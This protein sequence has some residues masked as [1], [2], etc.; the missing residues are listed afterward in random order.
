MKRVL[1]TAMTAVLLLAPAAN[2]QKVNDNALRLK[3]E[4]SDT[5]ITDAK[6]NTKAATWINRGKVYFES[7]QEP[8]KSLFLGLDPA[9]LTIACGEPR[10]KSDDVWE[11][12]WVNVYFKN[13]KVSA[14]EQKA[15][16]KEGAIET[17][18]DALQ[19]AYE[20]DPK[21]ASKIKSQ[22]D[23]IVNYYN[24]LAAVSY[25]IPRYDLSQ[26]AYEIIFEAQTNPAYGTPDYQ[27]LFFAGQLAAYLGATTPEMFAKG[28]A[29]LT[30]AL[31]NGY[32][33]EEGNIYYYLFHCY[34]GQKD[35]DRENVVKAKN[36]LLEGVAKFPKND[37][38]L[39]GL[40]QLYTSEEGVGDPADLV[41]LI[42]KALANDPKN[43]DLWFGRGRVYYKL[44]NYDEC[45]NSFAKV[46]ELKPELF[47]GNYYLALFYMAKGDNLRNE[48]NSRDYR[49]QSEYDAEYQKVVD[50]YKD[51]VPWFEKA[52]AI[53]PQHIDSVDCLKSLCFRLRD[54]DPEY[55]EKYTKYNAMFKQMK[56]EE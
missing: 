10:K 17:A 43:V 28:E 50:V 30:K 11:Y 45:I 35:K 46:V 54:E 4:K 2:A 48:I 9:M 56:G 33:D 19:R 24:Q 34:Y 32:T 8:T 27:N 53:N 18:L 38:V 51:A 41:D 22:L 5:E 36:V 37:K 49:S 52:L 21:Q 42:D 31:A 12:A 26:R 55:M 20:L 40:M 47:D 39:D 16:I 1:L 23:N 15:F 3:L 25:E 7:I 13:G 29:L 14:W 6:K 44:K